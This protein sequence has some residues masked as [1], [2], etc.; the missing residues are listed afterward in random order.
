MNKAKCVWSLRETMLALHYIAQSPPREYG[1][2]HPNTV[3]IAKN[4]L[5]HLKRLKTKH[6]K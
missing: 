3:A 5:R 1:G 4:A 2:F 6:R